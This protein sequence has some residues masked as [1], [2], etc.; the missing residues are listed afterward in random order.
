MLGTCEVLSH[1]LRATPVHPAIPHFPSE[2]TQHSRPQADPKGGFLSGWSRSRILAI[3]RLPSASWVDGTSMFCCGKNHW[4][5]HMIRMKSLRLDAAIPAKPP[6]NCKSRWLKEARRK[7]DRR[8]SDKFRLEAKRKPAHA[9]RS[10]SRRVRCYFEVL[11][12]WL[13]VSSNVFTFA[14]RKISHL[15]SDRSRFVSTWRLLACHGVC[16]IWGRDPNE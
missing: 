3:V 5:L 11:N 16:R 14:S 7:F 10:I 8:I 15:G 12:R 1:R 4:G 9:R 6:D 13:Q 2:A